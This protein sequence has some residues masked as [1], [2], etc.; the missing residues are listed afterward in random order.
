MVKLA[1][2]GRDREVDIRGRELLLDENVVHIRGLMRA[3]NAG[4]LR[5]GLSRGRGS[6]FTLVTE[7]G[8]GLGLDVGDAG[9][10]GFVQAGSQV[11][12]VREEDVHVDAVRQAFAV[13]EELVYD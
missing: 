13:G 8:D 9:P 3:E 7:D 4:E 12:D 6:S 11:A 1:L 2:L 10:L 5:E